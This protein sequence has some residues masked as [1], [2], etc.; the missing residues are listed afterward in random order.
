MD[1]A[2]LVINDEVDMSTETGLDPFSRQPTTVR[3]HGFI[4]GVD[5]ATVT[6]EIDPD[7]PPKAI[8]RAKI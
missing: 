6:V 4:T 1:P 5:E 8:P 2:D 7:S 3:Q